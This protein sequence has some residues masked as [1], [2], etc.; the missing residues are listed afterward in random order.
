MAGHKILDW[1]PAGAHPPT[2]L[3]H[4]GNLTESGEGSADW[5]L[6]TWPSATADIKRVLVDGAQGVRSL[7]A[8]LIVRAAEPRATVSRGHDLQ[9][10]SSRAPNRKD[11]P[12]A[13]DECDEVA[14]Q[15]AVGE[16]GHP[17]HGRPSRYR[18]YN[19]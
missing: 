10:S 16:Q 14:D 18:H 1:I 3:R 6:V 5:T 7:T 17:E 11:N 12:E 2:S 15:T 13:V 4:G 8:L 9:S 19:G